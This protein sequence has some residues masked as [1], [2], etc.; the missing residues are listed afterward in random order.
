MPENS[1][2]NVNETFESQKQIVTTK[3]IPAL[4]KVIDLKT[5]PIGE[6]IL[7]EMIHQR[8]RHQREEAL[9]KTK[10][11]DAQ[12]KESMRRHKNSRRKEVIYQSV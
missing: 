7:Y 12:T 2:L 3:I 9:R 4:L 8:H 10:T 6:G 5:Y 11:T 1:K